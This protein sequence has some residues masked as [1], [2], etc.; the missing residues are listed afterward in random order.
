MNPDSPR[1]FIVILNWNGLSDTIECIESLQKIEYDNFGILIV[2]NGSVGDDVRVLK[3]KFGDSVQI[4]ENEVNRGFTVGCNIGIRYALEKGAD[5]ILLLNNDTIVDSKF[6]DHLVKVAEESQEIGI[7]G[8]MILYYDDPNTI[9]SMGCTLNFWR[10]TFQVLGRGKNDH[11]QFDGIIDVDFIGGAA[12]L[13]KRK[14]FEEIGLLYPPFFANWEET[15]FCIRAKKKGFRVVV[16]PHA[17]IWHKIARSLSLY[18]ERRTYLIMRN[19][20]LFMR[21]N[22]RCRHFLSFF[23]FHIT[24]RAPSFV[25]STLLKRKSKKIF[26]AIAY[27]LLDGFLLPPSNCDIEFPPREFV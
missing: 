27:A 22:A 12:M 3:S 8:P 4:V 25:F 14:V 18:D 7:L 23:I 13:I 15:D 1:V 2:D 17:K 21:R 26:S 24:V 19:A 9:D 16:V 10:G 5:Y 6:L 11:R 20:I